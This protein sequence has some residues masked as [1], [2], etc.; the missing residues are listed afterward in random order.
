MLLDEVLGVL[1]A[2]GGL[3]ALAGWLAAIRFAG[4]VPPASGGTEPIT[5]LKPLHGGEPLLLEALATL[6]EQDYPP[7]FQIVF[8]VHHDA[9]QAIPAVRALQARYPD[10]DIVLVVD[11]TRHGANPKIGNLINML[12]MARH[13]ILVLADSD[14]HACPDYLRRLSGAL[15]KP[16]VG[17][18][19]TLYTGFPASRALPSLL[20][21][22]QITYDFL[23]GALLA[24][25]TGRRDC[26]GATMC[27][28]RE[29]LARIG[30]LESL[31][32]HLADDNVLGQRVRAEGLDV[33]LA[34]TIVATTVPEHRFSALWRHELRWA[35]TIRSLEPFGFA[36]LPLHYP[37]FWAVLALI[38]SG[39]ALWAWILAFGIWGIRGLAVT[40]IHLALGG[41]LGGLAFR[42]PVWLLPLRDVLSAA[43]WAVS[44]AGRNV[45]W[46]GQT[47]QADTPPR[48]TP[49][50]AAPRDFSP[51]GF[52]KGS[53]AR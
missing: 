34:H 24:R 31:K 26:L 47:L 53:N 15:T 49:R 38:V 25:A 30:G 35:R 46:R 10:R 18:V 13:D 11:E 5:I 51:T 3:L 33:A 23:P 43:E 7:G 22:A 4:H 16:G 2:I 6:C 21:A 45:D 17:L 44:H 29:T 52:N 39:G 32:D 1:S 41:M 20:G 36:M 50:A 42:C 19:T 28:R 9:D 40:G 12:P 14:V 48:L 8:G 37:L 27:L